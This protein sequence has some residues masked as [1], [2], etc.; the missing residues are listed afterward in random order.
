MVAGAEVQVPPLLLSVAHMSKVDLGAR[1]IE[2]DSLPNLSRPFHRHHLSLLLGLNVVQ[3]T[4]CRYQESGLI[5][6]ISLC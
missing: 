3:C 5:I 4:E 1:F 2:M 6:L